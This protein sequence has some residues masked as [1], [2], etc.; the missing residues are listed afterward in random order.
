MQYL[1]WNLRLGLRKWI[2]K[3]FD[4]EVQNVEELTWK[5]NQNRAPQQTKY[6]SIHNCTNRTSLKKHVHVLKSGGMQLNINWLGYI[7]EEQPPNSVTTGRLTKV[8]LY[9]SEIHLRYWVACK[10]NGSETSPTHCWD[11]GVRNDAE[12][13][14][15]QFCDG[16][17]SHIIRWK[18][19]EAVCDKPK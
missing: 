3:A 4:H 12:Q 15:K 1:Q 7:W 11:K 9:D 6:P 16:A 18:E 2:F 13:S 10:Q 5:K 19:T 8:L 17:V 14:I